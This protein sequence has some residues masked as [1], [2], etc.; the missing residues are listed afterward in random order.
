ME[1]NTI[2]WMNRYAVKLPMIMNCEPSAVSYFFHHSYNCFE[3]Y[4]VIG[5][6][7][8]A[9]G[10]IFIVK[11]AD[12]MK[13]LQNIFLSVGFFKNSAANEFEH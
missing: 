7:W 5:F 4:V 2:E 10:N 3:K 12:S 8:S 13:I 11:R 9:L 1:M 6:L